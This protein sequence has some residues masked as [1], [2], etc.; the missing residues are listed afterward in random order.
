MQAAFWHLCCNMGAVMND[1]EVV[2]KSLGNKCQSSLNLANNGGRRQF[3]VVVSTQP[4]IP[5]AIS[6][7]HMS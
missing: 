4:T 5:M 6:R 7:F 1:T 3:A 2:A